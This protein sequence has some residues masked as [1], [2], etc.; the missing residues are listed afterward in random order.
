MIS[1]REASRDARTAA[2][3]AR[4]YE[5]WLAAYK[6]QHHTTP[7]TWVTRGISSVGSVQLMP[8]QSIAL[9]RRSA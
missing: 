6:A 4:E 1:T 5:A 7:C 3:L 2:F 8:F 9:T